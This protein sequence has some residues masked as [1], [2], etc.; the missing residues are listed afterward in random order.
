MVWLSCEEFYFVFLPRIMRI[1]SNFLLGV[2]ALCSLSSLFYSTP[3]G[4]WF[5][6]DAFLVVNFD[7][8]RVSLCLL[9]I[10]LILTKNVL[11]NVVYSIFG[12]PGLGF[13]PWT[14]TLRLLS[15][16]LLLNFHAI[17]VFDK[18][19]PTLFTEY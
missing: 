14:L 13:V 8:F 18:K 15:F 11:F 4:L 10:V 19:N 3:T 6:V 5:L 1:F 17:N 2:F 16:L 7:P 12:C 9:C